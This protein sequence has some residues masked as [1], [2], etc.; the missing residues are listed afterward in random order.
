MA[1]EFVRAAVSA[2]LA[3]EGRREGTAGGGEGRGERD[4]TGSEE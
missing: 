2:A 3:C 4:E 1:F